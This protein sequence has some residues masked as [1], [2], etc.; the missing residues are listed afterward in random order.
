MKSERTQ[1]LKYKD[2][3]TELDDA[4]VL[5]HQSKYCSAQAEI[6]YISQEQ[7]NCIAEAKESSQKAQDGEKQLMNIEEKVISIEKQMRELLGDES[8][9]LMDNLNQLRL[10]IDRRSDK[11][12]EAE[13]VIEDNIEKYLELIFLTVGLWT[14]EL[15]IFDLSIGLSVRFPPRGLILRSQF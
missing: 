8:S 3:K 12:S 15:T 2:S 14:L 11:I 4:R 9:S 10:D 1:A 6:D 7:S 13:Q 5:L